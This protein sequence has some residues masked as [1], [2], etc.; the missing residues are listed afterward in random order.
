MKKNKILWILV[1][2]LVVL[3]VVLIVFTVLLLTKQHTENRYYDKM[4]AA[5]VYM[6]DMDYDGMVKAYE[7]AI[8]LMPEDPDA[9]I[10]LS[11]YYL[12]Q[13]KYYNA[14]S[15]A[16]RGLEYTG[17]R[18]LERLIAKIELSRLNM[19][20]A[21]KE[22]QVNAVM[23]N[24]VDTPKL[25]IKR[26]V[27]SSFGEYCYQEYLNEYGDADVTYV[28]DEVGY[29][30][31]FQGLS[32]YAYFKDSQEAGKVI[33]RITQ[34]PL[35]NA[36]P[37]KVVITN[38]VL[39]FVGY[40]GYISSEKLGELFHLLP[41]SVLT[42]IDDSYYL[43][44]E[45][46]GCKVKIETDEHGNMVKT[47]PLIEMKPINLISDWVEE[48]DEILSEEDEKTVRNDSFVLAGQVYSY[49]IS[50]LIITNAH[51][52]DL[53]PLANCKNLEYIL[54]ENCRIE[55]MSPLAKCSALEFLDIDWCY[56]NLDLI[57]VSKLPKL[58]YLS[59]HECK[60]IDDISCLFSKK[61]EILHPCGSSVTIEQ[62]LEYQDKYP[63][64]EVWFDYWYPIRH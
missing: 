1:P 38:P 23:Q 19:I 40:E 64:C 7:A 34:K 45:Y 18:R 14:I 50:E 3:I 26:N 54:F 33:D 16:E 31:K 58:E 59:F 36:K 46:L 48:E 51:L 27:V 17:S 29:Q 56:G 25:L 6:E 37:Y 52:E 2:L 24:Q 10:A 22:V 39:L 28:S 57:H 60:E 63:D 47:N 61:L 11:E 44:F 41:L 5:E 62:C 4:E 35:P 55:D 49:N 15:L 12:E 9:Y 42:C 21:N 20:E 43:M 8:E 30:V 13:G 53:S 32:A